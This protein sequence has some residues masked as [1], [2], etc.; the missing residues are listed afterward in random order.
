MGL[1]IIVKFCAQIENETQTVVVAYVKRKKNVS[2]LNNYPIIRFVAIVYL[3]FRE[4]N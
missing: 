1:G 4:E 3:V 2:L